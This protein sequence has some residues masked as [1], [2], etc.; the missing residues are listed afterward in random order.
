MS[1]AGT[2]FHMLNKVPQ[3]PC[4]KGCIHFNDCA[5]QRLACQ[6]FV[7][8]AIQGNAQGVGAEPSRELFMLLE[9][10]KEPE[11][12]ATLRG[13]RKQLEAAGGLK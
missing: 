13:A 4:E 12:Y 8:Y 3:P 11:A 2:V 5:E 9:S 10:D 1:F 6:A 7:V